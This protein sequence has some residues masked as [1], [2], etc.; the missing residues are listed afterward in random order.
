MD[1]RTKSAMETGHRISPGT[2]ART[3]FEGASRLYRAVA[4]LLCVFTAEFPTGCGGS[5]S[6]A[7]QNPM[8]TITSVSPSSAFA[9]DSGFTLTVNGANFV[10]SSTVQWNGSSRTT[11][12]VS[13]ATL[14]A[15]INAADLAVAN[16]ATVTVSTPA[17]GG[18]TSAGVSFAINPPIPVVTISPSSTI[19]AAGGQQQFQATVTNTQNTAVTW[20]VNNIPGGSPAV[21]TISSSGLYIAPIIAA[22]VTVSAVSQADSQQS[23]S[24]NLVVLAPHSIGVRPTAT[25]AEFFDKTTGNAFVPR[26]NNY[27]RL[28]TLTDPKGNPFAGHSTFVV[29]LYDANRAESALATMQT[30]GYNVARVFLEGCC[31]NTIGDPAGGLS[32]AYIA[33][34]VDFLQR[35]RT[36]GIFVLTTTSWLPAFGGYGPNCPEYPQFNDINL[37][38]LCPEAVPDSV[39]FFHDFVQALIQKGAPLDAIFA[40]ELYNEYTYNSSYSPLSW[41]SGT[42]TT[43][44]GKTYDMGSAVS[45]QQMMDDGLIYFTD[46]M[47]AAI[48][49]LDPTALVT[50]G[51]FVPQGPNPTRIGDPRVITVYPAM[52]MSTA[53]YVS[54]HPYPIAG[55]LTF[56]QYAQ[57]FGFV[58]YQ[59]QKPVVLEE[60]GVLESNYPVESTAATVAHDWQVQSCSYGIKGWAFWT[61]DT[62]NSEQVDGP[63]W[64]ASL[65]A[66][67]ISQT[68]SPAVRPDPCSP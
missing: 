24:A 45:R 38:K 1:V 42:I 14:Q 58:G 20:Q 47:R 64:P 19:V 6:A 63:F 50:V 37:F 33:N 32:S 55:D 53:D 8:P 60:F 23:G 30:S 4:L 10:T 57:N 11:T 13:G 39:K 29:G 31:Q 59:Q 5:G 65:G 26:G 61:W 56:A 35:A 48:L 28:A 34:V 12:F 40:Y 54:I 36:H 27:I 16:T 68:L 67:L 41:T 66:G 52:A 17:P 22:N 3:S 44:N 7:I 2:R 43:A 62:S 46:Q 21:G 51:F 15:A 9:G 18:G 49:A 25:I